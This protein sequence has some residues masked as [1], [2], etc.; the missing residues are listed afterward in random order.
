MDA[1]LTAGDSI[2]SA[3]LRN[4]AQEHRVEGVSVQWEG[5]HSKKPAHALG[6]YAGDDGLLIMATHGRTG[7]SRL[8]MGSVT[9][10]AVKHAERPVLVT[11]PEGLVDEPD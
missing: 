9:T 2:D 6:E 10:H 1:A 5:L 4:L 8:T 7:L 3:Y 11:C